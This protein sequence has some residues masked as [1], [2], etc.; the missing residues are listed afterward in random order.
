MLDYAAT[1]ELKD[2]NVSKFQVTNVIHSLIVT[3]IV[4][5]FRPVLVLGPLSECVI[6]KLCIDFP[7]QFHRCQP[8][9]MRCTKEDMENGVQNN[10][11]ADYRRRGSLFEYT[12]IQ[13]ILD[14][15]VRSDNIIIYFIVPQTYQHADSIF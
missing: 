14:N 1:S 9:Q 2:W 11:I 8:S 7:E 3:Y 4:D 5:K 6:E 15:K 10:A 12:T 13:S